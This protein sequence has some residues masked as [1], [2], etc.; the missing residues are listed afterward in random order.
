MG[1]ISRA[2]ALV[3]VPSKP[4]PRTPAIVYSANNPTRK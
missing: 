2:K 3:I 1:V 4:R